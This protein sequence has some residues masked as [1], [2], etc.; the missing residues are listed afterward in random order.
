MVRTGQTFVP[1]LFN[2]RYSYDNQGCEELCILECPDS[3]GAIAQVKPAVTA[4]GKGNENKS[5]NSPAGATPRPLSSSKPS[6][7]EPPKVSEGSKKK[8]PFFCKPCHF[9]AQDEQQF[10]EHLR[11][12]SASK[13]MVVN[14]VEGRSR[15]R[16]KDTDAAKRGD[17]DNGGDAAA[18]SGD[19]KGLIRCERCGYNTNRFDHYIAHLKH[20]SKQGEDH[21]YAAQ[22]DTG[23]RSPA[24]LADTHLCVVCAGCL[25]ARCV[26][27]PRSAS[28]TGGNT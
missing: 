23:A 15:T 8:K 7:Q 28:T 17:V 2:V 26:R 6:Q 14:R 21:R 4:N 19:T 5:A 3:P 11:T 27:T 16:T 1:F 18:A 25:S 9:Q 12:H 24:A 22:V 13:M 10:V 20:H